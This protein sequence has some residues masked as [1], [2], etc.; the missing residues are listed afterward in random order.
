[1]NDSET[2]ALIILFFIFIIF[3][4]SLAAS[5]GSAPKKSGFTAHP[6]IFDAGT[7]N[8]GAYVVREFNLTNNHPEPTEPLNMTYIC[9]IGEIEWNAENYTIPAYETLTCEF[10]LTV[11]QNATEGPFTG[12][13]T[14]TG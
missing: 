14:V 12:S 6:E 10:S 7:L 1:M 9:T 3:I 5:G 13:I 11:Y 8:P 4:A 2:L